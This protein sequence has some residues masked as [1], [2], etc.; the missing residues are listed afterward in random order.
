MNSSIQ[1]ACELIIF[2]LTIPMNI[3]K[4]NATVVGL[5]SLQSLALAILL[6]INA[7]QEKS[8]LLGILALSILVVKVYGARRL[9]LGFIRRNRESFS[10]GTYLNVP[11]SI[12]SVVLLTIFAQSSVFAPLFTS[13]GHDM[14]FGLLLV[15]SA[16]ISLFLAMN[17]KGILLQIIGILS[18]ENSIFA[19]GHF[20]D[21]TQ[22]SG[23]ELGIV[24][25]VLFW[26]IIASVYVGLVYKHHK[27]LDVTNLRELNK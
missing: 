20:F 2:L 25:D 15:A 24:F 3:V 19:M 18:L 10:T 5:Y 8:V 6:G 7:Y 16:L 1:A 21:P 13:A 23:L 9:F 26:M 14:R 12:A 22:S 17:R 27:S 11:L 4:K